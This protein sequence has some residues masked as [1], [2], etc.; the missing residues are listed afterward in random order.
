[1]RKYLENCWLLGIGLM[2]TA[3]ANGQGIGREIQPIP[4]AIQR[5]FDEI[6]ATLT[7]A[8]NHLER[9]E[10]DR[11]IEQYR[12]V[13]KL[14]ASIYG[15][16]G[17]GAYGLAQALTRADRPAEAMD[18]YAKA[19][20]W[21]ER[22]ND[23]SVTG[24]PVIEFAMD[25]AMLA[26]RQGDVARAK[27][28]YYFGMRQFNRYGGKSYEPIPF[29]VVFDPDPSPEME[30]WEYSESNL[31]AAALM[32]KVA[33]QGSKDR[34]LI[35]E[36]RKLAPNWSFPLAFLAESP[37]GKPNE[38]FMALALQLAR[39][40]QERAWIGLLKSKDRID[41][42]GFQLRKASPAVNTRTKPAARPM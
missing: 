38:E 31:R 33:S 17:N 16:R 12:R 34:P 42:T 35:D 41:L 37:V 21:E 39:N 13:M 9:N 7:V 3:T 23:W 27:E 19:V 8:D 2:L 26:A 10:L 28:M 29:L 36:V 22:R 30:V 20:W 25:Y 5:I 14:E 32:A 6:S 24:P 18:A 4:P 11:A 1:M 40:D 15:N